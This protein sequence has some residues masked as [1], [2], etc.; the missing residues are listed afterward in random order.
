MEVLESG[1]ITS[2]MG[3][4][5]AGC[6]G[7]DPEGLENVHEGHHE[8][9]MLELAGILKHLE[10]LVCDL[11]KVGLVIVRIIRAKELVQVLLLRGCRGLRDMHGLNRGC[12]CILGKEP[13]GGGSQ[14]LG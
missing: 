4:K 6:L 8:V 3:G 2:H 10:V 1:N 5:V 14:D 12:R 7:V 13:L 9:V 11:V